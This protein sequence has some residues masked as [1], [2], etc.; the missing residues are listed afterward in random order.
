MTCNRKRQGR[1]CYS[2]FHFYHCR[3][4][5]HY[6]KANVTTPASATEN[7]SQLAPRRDSPISGTAHR[8]PKVLSSG[9]RPP[10]TQLRHCC[11]PAPWG[12][13]SQMTCVQTVSC[14]ASTLLPLL[15]LGSNHHALKDW[16]WVHHWLRTPV[17]RSA[18]QEDH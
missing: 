9:L 1:T 6:R 3:L 5:H 15:I 10:L 7:L 14:I 17:L 2:N 13:S 8:H 11:G 18:A 4:H 12:L 16:P